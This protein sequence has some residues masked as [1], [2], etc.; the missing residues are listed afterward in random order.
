MNELSQFLADEN[1][2]PIRI[3]SI[4]NLNV[5]SLKKTLREVGIKVHEDMDSM[6][7]F[8]NYDGESRVAHSLN[9]KLWDINKFA[10]F[11]LFHGSNFAYHPDSI[12][13][14]HLKFAV[15]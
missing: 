3:V 15:W 14:D 1:S 12:L 4:K 2:D 13:D 8:K 11:V 10:G 5:D 9:L 7:M 6:T